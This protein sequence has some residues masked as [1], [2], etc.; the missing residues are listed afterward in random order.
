MKRPP[1]IYLGDL[2]QPERI[3]QLNRLPHDPFTSKGMHR[4]REMV[5]PK[6][7]ISRS[8]SDFEAAMS[9]ALFT[10]RAWNHD[11]F[12]SNPKKQDAVTI[13]KLAKKGATFAC[14]QFASVFVQLCHSVGIPARVLQVQTRRPSF[15]SSGHGHVTAEYFDNQHGKWVWIDPQIHAFTSHRQVPLSFS[16]FAELFSQGHRPKIHYSKRTLEYLKGDKTAFKILDNFLKRYIWS[17]A[18]GG[19]KAFFTNQEK[20]QYTGCFR[21]G[22]LPSITFQG[23][24]NET[25]LA[26]DR[27]EFDA[28]LNSCRMRF[29]TFAPNKTYDWKD[30]GDYK[31]NA[32]KNFATPLIQVS[33]ENSML[34]HKHYEVIFND[35]KH[36]FKESTFK[37]KLK[38]G[39]NILSVRPTNSFGRLGIAASATIYFDNRYQNTKNYW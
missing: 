7:I 19:K 32:Y 13:L 27:Q 17:A 25:P 28:P 24:A 12:N 6:K 39:K 38:K 14:V 3:G 22:V 9:L 33:I 10:S 2:M 21:N 8:K 16:E 37:L 15:G 18:V 23:F 30:L 31:N 34:W 35:R 4:L 29:K 1:R 26:L 20:F 5:Q 11:G 36:N